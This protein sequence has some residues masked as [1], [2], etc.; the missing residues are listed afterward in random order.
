MTF[1]LTD[2]SSLYTRAEIESA[3]AWCAQLA[4][5]H[6]ENFTV[7]ARFLPLKRRNEY[8]ALYA[9]A[10]GADDLAD[11]AKHR[12]SGAERLIALDKWEE[13]LQKVFNGLRVEHPAF[14]ALGDVINRHSLEIYPF[15]KLLWAFRQDQYRGAYETWRDV[16][17]YAV[18]SANPVGHLVLRLYGIRSPELDRLSDF[19]CTGLQLVN[20][21]QDVR[22]DCID[23]QRIY[24]PLEDL[25][26]FNVSRTMML[27]RPAPKAVRE[28]IRFEY[29][30]AEHLLWQ[31]R[32]LIEA[33]PV[34][35]K[36]Q[37]IL[38]HG[39][40]RLALQQIRKQ[41]YDTSSGSHVAGV[42]KF[43]LLIRALRGKAL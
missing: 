3:Y 32:G 2:H 25:R 14:I 20:F 40:G 28:L 1:V 34:E 43:L 39:G 29:H 24:L 22:E 7:A 4:K 30:R 21:I 26:R 42:M 16:E 10:R 27:S 9:F 11:N 41:Q 6:Y 37:L 15:E 19:I 35:L 18:G 23:R 38:F 13:K 36:R 31:G 12:P 33:V 8:F 5:S 17:L